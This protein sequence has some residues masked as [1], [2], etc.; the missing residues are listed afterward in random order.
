LRRVLWISCVLA[1][2]SLTFFLALRQT[3]PT[4]FTIYQDDASW[5][6]KN[7]MAVI[8]LEDVSSGTYNTRESL[9]KLEVMANYL[10]DE[11]VPFQVSLI[12]VYV[13]PGNNLK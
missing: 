11:G 6:A 13:D 8:R 9:D 2:L 5:E 7:K 10:Y 3:R 12:P 4:A 1:L